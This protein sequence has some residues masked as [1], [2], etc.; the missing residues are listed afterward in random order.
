MR[1]LWSN[2]R[3]RTQSKAKEQGEDS[4]YPKGT[5]VLLRERARKSYPDPENIDNPMIA[6]QDHGRQ[7]GR[8]LELHNR[9]L[10]IRPTDLSWHF[11][12]LVI[13][14]ELPFRNYRGRSLAKL[15]ARDEAKKQKTH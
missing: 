12:I 13:I 11:P 3:Q 10:W 1:K 6:P 7:S 9:D 14:R 8:V 15:E 4:L 5:E 2:T